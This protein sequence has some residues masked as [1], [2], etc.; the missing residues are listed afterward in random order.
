MKNYMSSLKENQLL[1][2]TDS[3]ESGQSV[4]HIQNKLTGNMYD[5]VGDKC[6]CQE[7]VKTGIPCSHMIT[8]VRVNPQGQYLPMF[9]QRWKKPISVMQL[10]KEMVSKEQTNQTVNRIKVK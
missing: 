9:A 5:I 1:G 2:K 7:N 4:T 8:A 10:Q 6:T 3:E